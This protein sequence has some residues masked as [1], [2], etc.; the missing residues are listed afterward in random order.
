MIKEVSEMIE[1]PVGTLRQW[2]NDFKGIVE[3]P[4]DSKG[5]RYYTDFEIEIL[6]HIK[7]MRDKKLSK[8]IIRDLLEKKNQIEGVDVASSLLVPHSSFIP[9]MKQSEA[10]ETLQMIKEMLA[11]FEEFKISLIKELREEIRQEVKNEVIEKVRK[12]IASSSEGQQVF[13]QENILITSEQLEGVSKSLREM[14]KRYESELK[15]RDEV[16]MENMRLLQEVKNEQN[17]GF[18]G[19]LFRK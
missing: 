10:I 18:L 1:V 17:K 8:D 12:E 16:V 19:K 9:Q 15:R 2:E 5:S 14:E 11:G 6:K 7:I 13:L 4:R 3:I